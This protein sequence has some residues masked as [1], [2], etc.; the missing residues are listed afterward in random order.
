MRSSEPGEEQQ[1]I[2]FQVVERFRRDGQGLDVHGA[3]LPEFEGCDAAEGRD[4]LVLLA[5]RFAQ[6][7]DLD[8]ARLFSQFLARKKVPVQGVQRAQQRHGEAARRAQAGAAGISERLTI[9]TWAAR[10][11]GGALRG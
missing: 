8:V 4:V 6:Q 3:V 10:E 2:V 9:F 11:P 1:Q 7:I 5:H